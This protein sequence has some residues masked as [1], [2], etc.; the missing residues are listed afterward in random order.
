MEHTA[1]TVSAIVSAIGG[2]KRSIEREIAALKA[3][4]RIARKGTYAG[5]WT[6][7]GA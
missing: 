1:T 6:V 4:G 7:L 3:S 5:Q 2:G